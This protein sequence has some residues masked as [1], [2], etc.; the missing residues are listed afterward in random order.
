LVMMLDGVSDRVMVN[1]M[2]YHAFFSEVVGGLVAVWYN[3]YLGGCWMVVVK[4]VL[5]LAG[6]TQTGLPAK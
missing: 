5:F 4:H 1:I 6:K 3:R 2:V